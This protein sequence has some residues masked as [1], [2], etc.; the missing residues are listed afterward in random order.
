MLVGKYLKDIQYANGGI[1]K[2][3]NENKVLWEKKST[4]KVKMR[5]DCEGYSIYRCEISF[6]GEK[7]KLEYSYFENIKPQDL[8]IDVNKVSLNNIKV[9]A[10]TEALDLEYCYLYFTTNKGGQ[11]R[12]SI[13]F[14]LTGPRSKEGELDFNVSEIKPELQAGDVLTIQVK[15]PEVQY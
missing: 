5:M 4:V 11:A 13:H 6:G 1:A 3:L 14:M 15:I 9:Y 8:E 12:D 2:V 7:Y 10:Y